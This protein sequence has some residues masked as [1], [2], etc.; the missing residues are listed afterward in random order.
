MRYAVMAD[1]HSNIEALRAVLDVC[2]SERIDTYL[3]CG[4][5][6][7]YSAS[8]LECLET[9]R[10][11]KMICVAGNHDWA[12]SGKLDYD[13]F[14]DQGKAGVEYAQKVLGDEDKD[15]LS[16]LHLVQ[17][18]QD[19]FMT[20]GTLND[21]QRFKYLRKENQVADIT[22][23][24]DRALCFLGHTHAA[25]VYVDF[26]GNAHMVHTDQVSVEANGKYVVNVGSV[27]QPRDGNPQAAF[28]IYDSTEKVIQIRRMSYDIKKAQEK[29]IAARLPRSSADRLRLGK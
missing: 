2:K 27:G 26:G 16:N 20:H 11:M 7:G 24:M 6:V 3:C 13:H 22:Y 28:C 5:L 9:V 10:A 15:W 23:L 25:N 12:V 8:P 29:I 17:K 21:P 14:T 18:N 1:I 19:C 4:D